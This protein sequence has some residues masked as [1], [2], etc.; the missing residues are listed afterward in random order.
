MSDT[1]TGTACQLS[2]MVNVD[3]YDKIV[4]CQML[5]LAIKYLPNFGTCREYSPSK[6]SDNNFAGFLGN[7]VQLYMLIG[8]ND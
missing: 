7:R 4:G 2:D 8:L 1:E 3:Y 6:C 5:V